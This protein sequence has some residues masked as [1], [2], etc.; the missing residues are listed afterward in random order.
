MS[1]A[2]TD[3]AASATMASAAMASATMASAAMA[4]AGS[5]ETLSET[6][7]VIFNPSYKRFDREYRM[8]SDERSMATFEEIIKELVRAG[9]QGDDPYKEEEYN[10]MDPPLLAALRWL[11]GMPHRNREW[12]SSFSNACNKSRSPWHYSGSVLGS[13]GKQLFAITSVKCLGGIPHVDPLQD[14][15]KLFFNR[16]YSSLRRKCPPSDLCACCKQINERQSEYLEEGY[17]ELP[18]MDMC[19]TA[20][21]YPYSAI[22]LKEYDH[23]IYP[24]MVCSGADALKR[25]I[26]PPFIDSP[27]RESLY[28]GQG[29]RMYGPGGDPDPFTTTWHVSSDIIKAYARAELISRSVRGIN[30]EMA[31]LDRSRC[32]PADIAIQSLWHEF[33]VGPP[34]APSKFEEFLA[35][36]STSTAGTVLSACLAAVLY[37]RPARAAAQAAAAQAAAAQAAAAQAAAAAN[38]GNRAVILF[39]AHRFGSGCNV[40]PFLREHEHRAMGAVCSKVAVAV[41]RQPPWPSL[42]ALAEEL[43]ESDDLRTRLLARL[44]L[45]LTSN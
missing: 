35:D 1:T 7:S 22:L 39:G 34:G 6:L 32:C 16:L 9:P 43:C 10:L 29:A 8:E 12:Y 23:D 3:S 31:Q 44:L 11:V 38:E 24:A 17:P 41:A 21:S 40:L 42:R 13:D 15:F 4:S 2:T 37:I 45:V 5:M 20:H 27:T 36:P 25:A 14:L 28:R 19:A 33:F 18:E 26:M 30:I